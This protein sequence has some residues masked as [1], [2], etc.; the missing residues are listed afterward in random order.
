E[1]FADGQYYWK[2]RAVD[3]AGN[4][5]NWSETWIYEVDTVPPG[6]VTRVSPANGA[7]LDTNTPTF[8]WNPVAGAV[9]Y[10]FYLVFNNDWSSPIIIIDLNETSFL[11]PFAIGGA[12]NVFY[13]SVRAIDAAGNFG[14]YDPAWTFT[15]DTAVVP[16]FDSFTPVYVVTALISAMAI[17][18]SRVRIRK[19]KLE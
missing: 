6:I 12:S 9:L 15:I 8:T 5:G 14:G 4:I 18:L 16:E 11:L 17:V 3:L 2:L 13:W 10:R 19:K 1:S 7:V